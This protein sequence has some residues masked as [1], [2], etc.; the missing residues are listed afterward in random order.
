MI[1]ACQ[2]DDSLTTSMFDVTIMG[3]CG[4]T[5]PCSVHVSV[6][7]VRMRRWK[8]HRPL[9]LWCRPHPSRTRAAAQTHRVM[10]TFSLCS[11][12]ESTT[13]LWQ[14]TDL[15]SR[16]ARGSMACRAG[17]SKR[18]AL[19]AACSN[20]RMRL[21]GPYIGPGNLVCTRHNNSDQSWAF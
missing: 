12:V 10:A 11:N 20:S 6:S 19:C 5:L 15:A 17:L 18:E 1:I 9:L 8:Q 13:R 4:W 2:I 3:W 16:F 7:T 21:F 14:R